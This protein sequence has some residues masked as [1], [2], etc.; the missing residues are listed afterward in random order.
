MFPFLTVNDFFFVLYL[1]R[2]AEEE[3]K[4]WKIW[5]STESESSC[6]CKAPLKLVTFPPVDAVCVCFSEN[7]CRT[8]LRIFMTFLPGVAV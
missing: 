3:R 7:K 1:T 5:K 4:Q 2:D 6:R 8:S